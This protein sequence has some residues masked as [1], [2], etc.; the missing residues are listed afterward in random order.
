MKDKKP[1]YT[2]MC[3]Y[4]DNNINKPDADVEKIFNYLVNLS[5]MLAHKR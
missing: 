3:I 2:E 5:S 1:T 4:V